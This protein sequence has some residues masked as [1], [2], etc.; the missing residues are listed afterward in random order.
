MPSIAF[1][2]WGKEAASVS[3]LNF[4]TML[5]VSFVDKGHFLFGSAAKV[6]MVDYIVIDS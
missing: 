5:W 1:E 4:P 2:R 3:G 6:E